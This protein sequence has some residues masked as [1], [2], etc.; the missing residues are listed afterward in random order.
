MGLRIIKDVVIS[1]DIKPVW[2]YLISR[3]YLNGCR[4][5]NGEKRRRGEVLSARADG[6]SVSQPRF[7]F[8]CP[9]PELPVSTTIELT[10][11]GRRCSLKV[12]VGG[13]EKVGH[14]R[15]KVM[16][17]KVALEWEKRLSVIKKELES[18]SDKP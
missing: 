6:A 17:P 9:D 10:R 5:S 8:V 12:I 14:E 7:S 16:M 11:N 18:A 15:T 2:D 4:S 13:W 1:K 3:P